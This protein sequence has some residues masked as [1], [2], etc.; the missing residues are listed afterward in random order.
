LTRNRLNHLNLGPLPVV[1]INSALDM[2]L[3]PGTVIFSASAQIHSSRR[4]PNDYG[5]CLPFVGEVVANALYVGDDL[6]NTNK[7]EMISRIPSL[8]AGLLVAVEVIPDG[9]GHYNVTSMYP[10]KFAIIEAR[11]SKRRLIHL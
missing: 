9:N 7:I 3:E 6:K 5:R 8:G 10:I 2:E 11:R 1:K 4:H